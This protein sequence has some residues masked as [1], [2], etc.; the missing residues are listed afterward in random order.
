VHHFERRPSARVATTDR[1]SSVVEIA[2]GHARVAERQPEPDPKLL[3]RFER[4]FGLPGQKLL[5]AVAG[6]EEE[7]SAQARILG[8]AMPRG[9]AARATPVPAAQTATAAARSPLAGGASTPGAIAAG[10]P[11]GAVPAALASAPDAAAARGRD[12]LLAI[13]VALEVSSS[14]LVD[15]DVNHNLTAVVEGIARSGPFDVVVLALLTP[16][17]DRLNGRFG[18]GSRIEAQMPRVTA[19]VRRGAGLLAE[20]VIDGAPR[21]VEDG[22]AAMLVPAGAPIPHIAVSSFAIQPL[23]V[24]RLAIGV[25]F[26]GR[27]GGNRVSRG[28]LPVLQML[29]NLACIGLREV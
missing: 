7:L 24:R 21:I 1:L 6:V 4:V 26:A 18:F 19:P 20:A 8:I 12:A 27:A 11:A 5:D 10:A 14:I 3:A 23:V 25:V 29:C 13:D 17:R 22:S 15:D 28:D 16:E 2:D 9:G